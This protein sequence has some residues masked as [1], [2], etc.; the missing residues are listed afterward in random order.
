MMKLLMLFA[1]NTAVVRRCISAIA[2]RDFSSFTPHATI[3]DHLFQ[4]KTTPVFHLFA[5]TTIQHPKS[6]FKIDYGNMK[7]QKIDE[8]SIGSDHQSSSIV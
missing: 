4:A 3:T 5:H 2:S 1:V 8:E 6:T 7:I